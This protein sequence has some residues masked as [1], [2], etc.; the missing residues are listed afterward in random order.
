MVAHIEEGLRYIHLDWSYDFAVIMSSAIGF[1]FLRKVFTLAFAKPIIYLLQIP[2]EKQSKFCQ[3]LWFSVYYTTALAVGLKLLWN[4]DWVWEYD[5]FLN[6]KIFPYEVAQ[7]SETIFF[8]REYYLMEFGFYFQGLFAHLFIDER[9]KD[10]HVLTAHHFATLFLISVSFVSGFHRHGAP[11]MLIH[12]A[13]DVILYS[14][15]ALVDAGYK[16]IANILFLIFVIAYFVLRIWIFGTLIYISTANA[17]TAQGKRFM[18]T[19][20]VFAF[21]ETAYPNFELSA[22]GICLHQYCVSTYYTLTAGMMAL[23]AMHLYW[24]S[25]I[26]VMVKNAIF[27]RKVDDVRED[28]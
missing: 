21:K 6:P 7:D 22:Q 14:G 1:F 28:K 16:A 26:L 8:F 17:L 27:D 12:D 11:I 24:F 13:V 23:Y 20:Y 25:L 18:S 9:L 5:K 15:K 4:V 2:K 3:N 19:D 10:F